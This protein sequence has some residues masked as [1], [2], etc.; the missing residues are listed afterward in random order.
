L[1]GM[2]LIKGSMVEVGLRYSMGKEANYAYGC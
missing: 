2:P 1:P